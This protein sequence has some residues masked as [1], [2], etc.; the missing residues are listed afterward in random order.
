[1]STLWVKRL[2]LSAG[3]WIVLLPS[4]VLTGAERDKPAKSAQTA[5][6]TIGLFDGMAKGQIAA[7]LIV[8]D[9]T[10]ARVVIENK[11][12]R[13]LSVRLPEAFAGVPVLAQGPGPGFGPGPVPAGPNNRANPPQILGT[14]QPNVFGNPQGPNRGPGNQPGPFNLPI[15]GLANIPPEKVGQVKVVTVCLEHD[16]PGPRHSIPY[17]LKP[18]ESV[19]DKPG[20]R[21]VCAMV[22]S[23]EIS[24]QAGQAAAWHLNNG[25]SWDDLTSK[26]L[27]HLDGTSKPYF[28]AG[29]LKAAKQAAAKATQANKP[30]TA[31][32]P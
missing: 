6:N 29:E 20:V 23:G 26:Q 7:R 5:D 17:E 2:S 8:Q 9:S 4:S 14:G 18:I 28:T 11:T 12:D 10:Q 31:E 27:R 21:Q 15:P 24:Q 25:M 22:A 32:V 1:M 30:R 3:L 16:K 19:T 13:P